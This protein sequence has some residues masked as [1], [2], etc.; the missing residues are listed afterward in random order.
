M[1]TRD[2]ETSDSHGGFWMTGQPDGPIDATGAAESCRSC[3]GMAA[4]NDSLLT[5]S[6]SPPTGE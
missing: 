6:I 4:G 1:Y 3:H 2:G 5:G